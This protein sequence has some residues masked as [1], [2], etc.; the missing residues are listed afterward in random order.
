MGKSS[1]AVFFYDHLWISAIALKA[2]VF[3]VFNHTS[4][5]KNTLKFFKREEGECLNFVRRKN[6]KGKKKIIEKMRNSLS[7]QTQKGVNADGNSGSDP[8]IRRA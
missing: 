7:L 5:K 8:M 4:N 1:V 2:T 6:G 3:I